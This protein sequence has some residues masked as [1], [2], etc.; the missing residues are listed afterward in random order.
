MSVKI[1]YQ[2]SLLTCQ[3]LQF[4]HDLKEK[5]AMTVPEIPQ[6][7]QRFSCLVAVNQGYTFK[8]S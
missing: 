4:S 8:A 3:L 5:L 2:K 1:M 7:L 6:G